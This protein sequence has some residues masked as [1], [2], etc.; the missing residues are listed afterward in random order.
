[1][2]FQQVKLWIKQ[3][4]S[5]YSGLQKSHW[6]IIALQFMNSIII[7]ICYFLPLYF[8]K[9]LRF[10]VSTA[11]YIISF[12]GLGTVAGGIM[13]G[14][15]ADKVSPRWIV[16]ISMVLQS[17]AFILLSI[18][19]TPIFLM[20]NLFLLGIS[21]YSFIT[22]NFLWALS[23]CHN[24]E[25]QKIKTINILDTVANLGLGISALVFSILL[26][27]DLP[28]LSIVAGVTLFI[29]AVYLACNDQLLYK[30]STVT[31]TQTTDIPT[32]KNLTYP[33]H[34]IISIVITCLFLIGLII[35]QLS[36]TYSIYLNSLFPADNFSGFGLMFALNTF[37][38]VTLQTPIANYCRQ[39]NRLLLI[40]SG[41]F[42]L[43]LGMFMLTFSFSFLAVALACIIYTFGEI[44]FFSVAQLL[45]YENAPANK[46]GFIL[47]IYRV[48]YAVS[49]IIG[50]AA[51]G[52][53]YQQYGSNFLWFA[54]GAIGC[55]CLL[56]TMYFYSDQKKLS[57][58]S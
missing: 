38:V 9:Q 33:P 44:L 39:Y 30:E 54:C 56:T 1:M 5:H 11:G 57:L 2:I 50:P 28:L 20:M 13:G 47:G 15:T 36:S 55:V 26:M 3:Y 58:I 22:A 23:Y 14:G 25:Q 53:V 34:I 21:T 51:G 49:K 6:L 27:H 31:N 8:V 4:L 7:S 29:L 35:S 40:G 48:V 46:K 45:C 17:I 43:G 10:D 19:E 16:I 41:A 18:V 52:Y 42:L 24:N 12:Y 32:L 37:M